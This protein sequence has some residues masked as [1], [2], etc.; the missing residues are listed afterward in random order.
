MVS[1]YTLCPVMEETHN[2]DK[3]EVSEKKD[4]NMYPW[5]LPN[6]TTSAD[7]ESED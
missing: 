5:H 6:V 3:P 4:S 2:V 1:T 7:Y